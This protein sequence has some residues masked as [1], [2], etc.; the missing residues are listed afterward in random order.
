MD[1]LWRSDACGTLRLADAGREVR[2]AGWVG[3][4][5]DHGGLIF[6][7][8]RDRSGVVQIV[9]QPDDPELFAKA[10]ALRGEY[11]ISV[12][13]K[14][15]KRLEGME[16]PKLATGEI[17]VV[18]EDLVVLSE[19]KT[20]P[21]QI[22]RPGDVDERIRLRYRYLD[23]RRPALQRNMILRHRVMKAAR[24]FFDENGFLE[25]ET[26]MLTRS[27]P[28]GARDYLVPSRVHPGKFYALPQSPQI[29]KQLFMVSG[30]ER[31]YQIVR[32]FRDEDLRADRQPEFTQIDVEMSFVGRDD[33]M[34][35]M[36]RLIQRIFA[37]GGIDVNLP[38]RRISYKEAI[39]RY[40]SDKPDLRFGLELVDVT[41]IVRDSGFKV[42][43]D[44]AKDGLVKAINAKG[45]AR[46]SRREIDQLTE[47]AIEWG[48]KGLAWIAVGE[49]G[50]LR[51]AI[52]KFMAE[53]EIAAVLE[54]LAAEPDDLLLFVADR[55]DVVHTVLGRLRVVLG[56]KLGLI[57]P[58][59][60]EFCWVID[61]PLLEWDAEQGRYVA[62][63]HPFTS[64]KPEHL[65]L[66]ETDPGAVE[67]LAY[68]LVVNGVELG[69]G[70]IRIHR[71]DVQERMFKAL[72][73][74]P[75]EAH[76]KFGFLIEALSY[77]A[78]PHGGIAFG[79]DRVIMVMARLDSIRDCIPFP[80]TQSAMDLMTGA[81]SDVAPEQLEELGIRLLPSARGGKS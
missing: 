78:P 29:F 46:W 42:F 72:G 15:T 20:P 11:V 38:I 23:L 4:R 66:L 80:K 71:P 43:A 1:E 55:P 18:A 48:A 54:R 16:N 28:E 53:E 37:V 79:L 75:E 19:A 51:S 77:G 56:E 21:F 9:F 39:E 5:R 27:T 30:L 40:G 70:S 65:E 68:D 6:I 7:D 57:D 12:K 3:R 14:V 32:C 24:D 44:A 33:V 74:T 50:S 49:G 76:E 35:M 2:L 22:D 73:F 8:L 69:G 25:L 45:A 31:Y 64:P 52:T 41:D 61:W 63:H 10:E 58:E 36:E 47:Q 26:P 13:G 59:R 67:A 34:R 17:E 81:P 62:A 60:Y